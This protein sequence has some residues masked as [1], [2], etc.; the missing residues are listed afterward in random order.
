VESQVRTDQ[1][2]RKNFLPKYGTVLQTEEKGLHQISHGGRK[3]VQDISCKR[4][5]DLLRV[6]CLTLFKDK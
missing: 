3:E 2:T 5:L 6:H 1:Q 4:V